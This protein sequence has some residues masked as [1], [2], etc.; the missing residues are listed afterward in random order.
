MQLTLSD[1]LCGSLQVW[2][3]PRVQHKG[4]MG[5]FGEEGICVTGKVD[6]CRFWVKTLHLFHNVEVADV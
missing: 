4:I 6:R 3:T 1:L 5:V 2:P